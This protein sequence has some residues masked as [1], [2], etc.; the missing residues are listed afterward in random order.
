MDYSFDL[1][2]CDEHG[3]KIGLNTYL[4]VIEIRAKKLSEELQESVR[5]FIKIA[6]YYKTTQPDADINEF[7]NS[8]YDNVI[9][10]VYKASEDL[11]LVSRMSDSY[12]RYI[13]SMDHA[14]YKDYQKLQAR[15]KNYKEDR[16]FLSFIKDFYGKEVFKHLKKEFKENI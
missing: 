10:T 9:E 2:V 15:L 1:H 8:I 5:L 3:R 14:H 6:N 7:I 16:K 11:E 12:Y 4:P 13:S